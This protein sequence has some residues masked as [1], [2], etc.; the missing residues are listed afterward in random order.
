MAR[1]KR[2]DDSG[3]YSW[4]DTYGD[5][6]TLLLTFFVL[7]FASSTIDAEKFDILIRAFSNAPQAD[8]AQIALPAEGDEAAPMQGL[9]DMPGM[10]EIDLQDPKPLDLNELYEYLKTYVEANDMAGSVRVEKAANS[11]QLR[12]DNNIFFDAD[13][14]VLRRESFDVLSFMGDCFKSVED[15]ILFIR[16]NGHTAAIPGQ[17]DYKVNDWDLS[18]SRASQVASYFESKKDFDAAKLLPTGYGKNH[19]IASND[20][21]EGRAKN[22]RVDL[23]I[24]GNEFDQ[25]N[26]QEMYDI[27]QKT[28]SVDMFDDAANSSEI[29]TPEAPASAA[30]SEAPAVQVAPPVTPESAAAEPEP[31]PPGDMP[32]T[33]P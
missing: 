4:M 19:P 31:E 1:K 3:G 2:G 21:T 26:A 14:A 16:I 27:L 30:S 6:V 10:E 5:M 22:R 15:K 11:V 17:E 33:T 9:G 13:S 24:L 8:T 20:T 25:N 32:Q 12:F 23:M 18:T 28:L 7:L 29:L